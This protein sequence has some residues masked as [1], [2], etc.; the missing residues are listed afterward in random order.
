MTLISV[1]EYAKLKG[2]AQITVYKQIES[3]GI[4]P[5]SFKR[6]GRRSARLY[7]KDELEKQIIKRECGRPIQTKPNQTILMF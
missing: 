7:D 3:S 1:K 5:V 6:T 4:M 2:M